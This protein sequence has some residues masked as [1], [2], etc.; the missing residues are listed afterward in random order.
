MGGKPVAIIT[1][2]G[3]N[4][5]AEA[6]D[7][8]KWFQRGSRFSAALT[9]R[10]AGRGIDAEIVPFLWPGA[11]SASARETGAEKLAAKIKGM[12][13]RYAG[14][15]VV[16]H[17]HGGN[18]ANDAA[19]LLRW[20]RR[21]RDK[22]PI[23]SLTTIG[24]PFLSSKSSAAQSFGGWLF[25]AITW[26]SVPL[27]LLT[28]LMLFL[29]VSGQDQFFELNEVFGVPNASSWGAVWLCVL[30]VGIPL[31][32]M[33]RLAT[34]GL[35]RVMRPRAAADGHARV[36]S[37]WHGNDE[38]ISFLK[39][40]EGLPLEP[41]PSGSMMR[42]SRSGAISFGVL[43]V[44]LASI[45]PALIGVAAEM[46]WIDMPDYNGEWLLTAIVLTLFAAPVVF[47]LAY[48]L[49]RGIAGVV[50]EAL[51]R[52]RLNAWVTGVLRGIA[53]GRDGDQAIGEVR[54]GPHL[55][56]VREHRIEGEVAARMQTNA[57]AAAGKLIEQYRWALF[58]VGA[59]TNS[60]LA[61]LANDAMTWSSLIHTTYF[62]QPEVINLIAD[63][64]A[65]EVEGRGVARVGA[66]G[67]A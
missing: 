66:A 5:T 62:D 38:A 3:T 59:D 18:V 13:G 48:L 33:L 16:G 7:G 50:A 27:Y 41:F 1:V 26:L 58:T 63:Y 31:W 36:F 51:A 32:L 54:T 29:W 2:H 21:K 44:I 6:P 12:G 42:G 11:N 25:L 65:D 61:N 8:E 4:D 22:E 17:S 64:I 49:Y 15:H 35:R 14:V 55:H 20:G 9:Q 56:A 28:S 46:N 37:V 53:F 24:T 67:A 34:R 43:A 39:Q 57:A 40:I 45:S 60:P 47:A 10:L 30:G 19:L 23:A 52:Q